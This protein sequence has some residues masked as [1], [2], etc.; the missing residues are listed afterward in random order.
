VTFV[1]AN[2]KKLIL[3]SDGNYTRV[4][5]SEEGGQT[6]EFLVGRTILCVGAYT[7]KFLADTAPGRSK[8]QFNGRMI[9]AAAVQCKATYP[10]NKA[11]VYF[12]GM[13]HTH[14]ES[15]SPFNGRLNSTARS[16]LPT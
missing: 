8:L 7:E 14:G 15:I 11:P 3:D 12:L 2:A 4:L 13:W 16:A 9:T 6:R 5:I 1:K 10:L